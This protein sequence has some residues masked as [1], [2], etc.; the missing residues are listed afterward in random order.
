M[1][2]FVRIFFID[3]ITFHG[4]TSSI[5][6]K[7]WKIFQP[8]CHWGA[9]IRTRPMSI[10]ASYDGVWSRMSSVNHGRRRGS[11][12]TCRHFSSS[13]PQMIGVSPVAHGH[14]TCRVSEENQLICRLPDIEMTSTGS[15]SNLVDCWHQLTAWRLPSGFMMCHMSCH[16]SY[17]K[18]RYRKVSISCMI[19]Y[20]T[21]HNT[22]NQHFSTKK[23]MHRGLCWI[24][25]KGA[26]TGAKP[27]H[28][29]HQYL[30]LDS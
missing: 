21:P 29:R 22:K 28:V 16:L 11:L 19:E 1:V 18:C 27:R 24:T 23:A 8:A 20:C 14:R 26:M 13:V 25:I 12:R 6:S 2:D 7:T 3:A 10:T 17:Q 5:S 15:G 4:F 9:F 30:N